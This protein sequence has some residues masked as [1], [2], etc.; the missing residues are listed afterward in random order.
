[1]FMR[2]LTAALALAWLLTGCSVLNQK[3]DQAMA[4]NDD[5]G[6]AAVQFAQCMRDH[7]YPMSDPTYDD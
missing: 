3:P 7:G 1:M 5:I 2:M 6:R 4:K